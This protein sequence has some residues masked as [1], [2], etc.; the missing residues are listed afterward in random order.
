MYLLS[1]PGVVTFHHD[2]DIDLNETPVWELPWL[3]EE[4][5]MVFSQEPWRVRIG[6]ELDGDRLELEVEDDLSASVI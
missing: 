3:R 2:H 6:I 5:T 1:H 4:E